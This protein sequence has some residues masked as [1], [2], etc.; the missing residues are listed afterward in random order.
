MAGRRTFEKYVEGCFGE[1]VRV[2]KGVG[3]ELRWLFE[4]D[5]HVVTV[6]QGAG[7]LVQGRYEGAEVKGGKGLLNDDCRGGGGHISGDDG[8]RLPAPGTDAIAYL[9]DVWRKFLEPHPLHDRYADEDDQSDQAGLSDE[10]DQDELSGEDDSDTGATRRAP[11]S[12]FPDHESFWFLALLDQLEHYHH[13]QPPSPRPTPRGEVAGLTLPLR[14]F[15]SLQLRCP[16]SLAYRRTRVLNAG[17][18][19]FTR[20]RPA[21]PAPAAEESQDGPAPPQ[22]KHAR[23]SAEEPA[24]SWAPRADDRQTTNLKPRKKQKL[25]DVFSGFGM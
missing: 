5:R 24:P 1:G 13:R 25:A 14:Q 12:E 22:N 2:R 8:S 21:V 20:Q 16:P 9:D 4:D 23:P 17:R 11:N 19:I 15:V 7:G 18:V 6:V 3:E 10:D